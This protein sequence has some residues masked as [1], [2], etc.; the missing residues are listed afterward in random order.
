MATRDSHC[1]CL[2][3]RQWV[4]PSGSGNSPSLLAP[5]RENPFLERSPELALP[6]LQ[7]HEHRECTPLC[8]GTSFSSTPGK[9]ET[10]SAHFPQ[11]RGENQG[12]QSIFPPCLST[13][14]LSQL[15]GIS[16][17]PSSSHSVHRGNSLLPYPCLYRGY[18]VLLTL[19]PP[20]I[21]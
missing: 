7:L 19:L 2:P 12:F 6:P 8:G 18:P 14:L 3:G 1:C 10:L 5:P 16:F 9:G 11:G 20:P 17:H 13:D 4:C 15:E 21:A